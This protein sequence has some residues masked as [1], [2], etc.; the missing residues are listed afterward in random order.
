MLE[1]GIVRV[2]EVPIIPQRGNT[3]HRVNPGGEGG[4]FLDMA[5]D[6]R[7]PVLQLM[8]HRVIRKNCSFFSPLA[9]PY[10]ITRIYL[11]GNAQTSGS[12][13]SALSNR[14]KCW[15]TQCSLS[16]MLRNLYHHIPWE[17]GDADDAT[18]GQE[19]GLPVARLGSDA[20]VTAR[21]PFTQRRRMV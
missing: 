17:V 3:D 18:P 5:E 21:P 8:A 7:G 14:G 2:F 16:M 12:P 1:S 11:S 9:F 6:R 20:C 15:T 4:K 13:P 19:H 10:P